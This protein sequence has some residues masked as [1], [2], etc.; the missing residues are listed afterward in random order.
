MLAKILEH[1]LAT[2]Q[3]R[4]RRMTGSA[5]VEV[6]AARNVSLRVLAALR[7]PRGRCRRESVAGASLRWAIG[8]FFLMVFHWFYKVFRSWRPPK[9]GSMLDLVLGGLLEAS[10]SD[11]G[12]F[13]GGQEAPKTAQD[14]AK[15]AQDGAKT[16]QEAAK[17]AQRGAK[18][19]QNGAKTLQAGAETVQERQITKTLKNQ[20]KN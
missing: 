12:R 2:L 7:P 3:G 16:A 10:W 19:P 4:G 15:T 17:T 11:L 5:F 18:T 13:F 6:R 20:R 1:A 8:G 9:I 14:G